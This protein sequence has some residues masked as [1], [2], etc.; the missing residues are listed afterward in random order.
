ME[1]QIS[2]QP[3]PAETG[4]HKIPTSDES[5]SIPSQ[6]SQADPIP[7]TKVT[8]TEIDFK[9][10]S[11]IIS[12]RLPEAPEFLQDRL[13]ISIERRETRLLNWRQRCGVEGKT[14]TESETANVQQHLS[15]SNISNYSE[16]FAKLD[17]DEHFPRAPELDS[18]QS[19]FICQIC[20]LSIPSDEAKGDS[21]T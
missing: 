3:V 21:W 14:S 8:K 2:P 12:Q 10:A 17:N 4:T 15:S 13:T 20:M 1:S 11:R 19:H 9:D 6:F 16:E 7:I 18:S 5:S